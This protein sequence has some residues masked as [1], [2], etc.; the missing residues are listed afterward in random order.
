MLGIIEPEDRLAGDTPY[1]NPKTETLGRE[2][3][4]ALQLAKLRRQCE[5]AAARSPWYQRKFAEAGFEPDVAADD[6]G[7]ATD[8][9][10]HARRLDVLA[11][12]APAV[13][14]D[15]RDRRRRRDPRAHHVGHHRAR[16]AA[17]AGLAQ[18]LGVDRG[19]VVL[20]AVGLW[21]AA[22]R[23]R[24]HR[25]RVRVVHRL[26][27]PSLRDGE[28]GRAQRARRRAADR[29]AGAADPRLR[30]DRRRLDPDVRAAPRPGGPDPGAR[31]ARLGRAAA[32]PVGRAGGLDPPDQGA[33][34]GAV[35]SEGL[36]HRRHD[37]DRH[38]HG[39]RVLAPAGRHPHHRGQH[40][41]GGHRPGDARAGGLWRARRA[42]RD[43]VRARR[44]PADPLSHRRPRLQGARFT[45]RMRPRL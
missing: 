37:R 17:R 7:P 26:L 14:R 23:H 34:R 2:R 5:W 22:D 31:P 33:D 8:S 43:L 38:D 10:A 27:G 16:A 45:V 32:D 6:L 18:G 41:R 20:R 29:G 40:D 39:V 19:D 12:G 28:D 25:V 21:R 9:D 13:R 24:L 35:G 30:R 3:L 11:G 1:W 36:R 4:E 15:P 42:G 44:D